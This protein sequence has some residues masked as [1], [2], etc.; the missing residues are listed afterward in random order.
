MTWVLDLDGVVWRGSVAIPGSIDAIERVRRS[1]QRILYVTN[2]AS[3]TS[4]GYVRKLEML[5]VEAVEGDIVHGGHAVAGLISAGERVLTAAGPGVAEALTGHAEII[6]VAD[7]DGPTPR[8]DVAVIG[9][10]SD[11]QFEWLTR[12]VQAVLAGARLVVPSIDPLYPVSDGFH[13]GGGGLA[14]AVAY[15][16]GVVPEVAGKP[17]RPIADVVR[18]RARDA[19]IEIVV[20]DQVGTD[21]RLAQLL[22][23]PFALVSTGVTSANGRPR[24]EPA[25][26]DAHSLEPG[27]EVRVDFELEDLSA[28]VDAVLGSTSRVDPSTTAD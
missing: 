18:A 27:D 12:V 28:A 13:V 7:V 1:D 9:I 14:H 3:L 16:C 17:N 15:A 22:G 6:D 19:A 10:R 11:F 25:S 24:R 5:G 20:G 23:V 26:A 8:V 21:G 2:N 4:K